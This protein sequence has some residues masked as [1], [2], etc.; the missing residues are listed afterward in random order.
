MKKIVGKVTEEERNDIQGLCERKNSLKELALII[1]DNSAIYERLVAD[2]TETNMRYQ[3]W[4][5]TMSRKY[6]WEQCD[7][8]HWEIDFETCNIFLIG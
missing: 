7:N 5:N 2:L 6:Q 3:E 1:T 4:W 8:G